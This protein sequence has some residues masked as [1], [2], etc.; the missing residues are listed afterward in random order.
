MDQN[1]RDRIRIVRWAKIDLINANIMKAE[2]FRGWCCVLVTLELFLR[3]PFSLF[4]SESRA[5]KEFTGHLQDRTELLLSEGRCGY[6]G[7]QEDGEAL[8]RSSLFSS[9]Q[10]SVFPGPADQ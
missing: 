10:P 2:R 4:P 3:I 8:E 5:K 7:K 6:M 1:N 9:L